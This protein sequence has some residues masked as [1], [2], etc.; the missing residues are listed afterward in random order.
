MG[1]TWAH[2]GPVGPRLA[3]WW[4]H[5]PCYQ[6][7]H[8]C[9][10]VFEWVNLI[11][12]VMYTVHPKK[13]AHHLLFLLWLCTARFDQCLS[14]EY[15]T[16]G[17]V[18]ISPREA[19]IQNMG[20]WIISINAE[21][22]SMTRITDNI[23]STKDNRPIC[24]FH[25]IYPQTSNIKHTSGGNKIVDYSD[26]VE[27]APTSSFLTWHLAPMDW[28]KTTV[29]RD[30]KH[31]SLESR[32]YLYLIFDGTLVSCLA[33]IG[34]QC[35]FSAV[36]LEKSIGLFN[37]PRL[38]LQKKTIYRLLANILPTKYAFAIRMSKNIYSKILL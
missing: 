21:S 31:L 11:H 19:T 28:T 12:T 9:A 1:P 29:R 17:G 24:I 36:M 30:E 32:C 8:M 26:V 5:E 16:G 13:Y 25:A 3:P 14:P 2:L 22:V 38:N 23:N 35:F 27:A 18:L 4:P 33:F 37:Y 34:V 10:C 15:Y 20:E 7:Y 6:G